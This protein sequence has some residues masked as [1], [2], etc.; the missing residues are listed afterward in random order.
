[1]P[2]PSQ[3]S[4]GC[5][6]ITCPACNELHECPM[7]W[8]TQDRVPPRN[9]IDQVRWSNFLKD[10]WISPCGPWGYPEI[11]GFHDKED[12]TVLSVRCRRKDLPVAQPAVKRVPVRLW[13]HRAFLNDDRYNVFTKISPPQSAELYREIH[14]D[15]NGGWF[16]EVHSPW[17]P[18]QE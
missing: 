3:G 5:T 14:S 6:A 17:I 2:L 12:G 15:G 4:A 7:D 13:V 16:V 18:G 8:V 1:M 10:R 9:G 11:H